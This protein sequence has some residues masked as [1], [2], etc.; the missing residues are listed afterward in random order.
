M[1]LNYNIT[2]SPLILLGVELALNLFP[3]PMRHLCFPL[4]LLCAIFIANISREDVR[5]YTISQ[6][7]RRTDW[8]SGTTSGPTSSWPF[9]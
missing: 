5:Q 3:F 9:P 4:G 2:I 6:C 8:C 7:S 1:V